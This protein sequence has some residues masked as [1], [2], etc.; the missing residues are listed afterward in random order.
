MIINVHEGRHWENKN[1][2]II[3]NPVSVSKSKIAQ[4]IFDI[5]IRYNYT[6]VYESYR[7]YIMG[8]SKKELLGDIQLVQIE[9]KKF[10]LNS[11]VY[12]DDELNYKALIKTLVELFNLLE[13][14]NITASISTNFQSI[15]DKKKESIK[16]IIERVFE[17]CKSDIYLYN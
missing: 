3:F 4:E 14:Y 12:Y 10:V 16:Q 1:A 15:N 2:E 5:N 6:N 8:V 11:F 9:D 13:K 17:D 7:D